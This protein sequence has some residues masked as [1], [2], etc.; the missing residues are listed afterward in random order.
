MDWTFWVSAPVIVGLVI[1]TQ[2]AFHESRWSRRPRPE[3]FGDG[4]AETDRGYGPD[5]G[6]GSDRG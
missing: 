2:W 1:W 4:T 5:R 6:W 3:D